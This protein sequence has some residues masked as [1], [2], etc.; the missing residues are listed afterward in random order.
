M[1]SI[2]PKFTP[3]DLKS[4]LNAFFGNSGEYDVV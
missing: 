3:K 4:S 1:F 2:K